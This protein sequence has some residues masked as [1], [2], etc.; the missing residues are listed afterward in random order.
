MAPHAA[1]CRRGHNLARR[2]C[3]D[4]RG[5]TSLES[6]LTTALMSAIAGS[7]RET[8][9]LVSQMFAGAFG[10]DAAPG[11]REPRKAIQSE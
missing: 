8:Q 5:G 10:S 6:A 11:Y 9:Y 1:N 3:D 7:A 2:H 4:R